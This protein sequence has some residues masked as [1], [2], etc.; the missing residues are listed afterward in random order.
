MISIAAVG[1]SAIGFYRSNFYVNNALDLRMF[2]EGV[3]RRLGA[4]GDESSPER[5]HEADKQEYALTVIFVNSGNRDA[6]VLKVNMF[7]PDEHGITAFGMEDAIAPFAM[8]PGEI[9]VV[10][11]PFLL[12]QVRARRDFRL[13]L[14]VETIDSYGQHGYRYINPAANVSPLGDGSFGLRVEDVAIRLI[15]QADR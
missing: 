8:K 7:V 3:T 12:G 6:L 10:A 11:L 15:P 2:G 5:F 14:V 13:A 4:P 1:I 9:K